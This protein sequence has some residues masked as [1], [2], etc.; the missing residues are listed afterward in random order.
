MF[1]NF[2]ELD[3]IFMDNSFESFPNYNLEPNPYIP[4]KNHIL[5]IDEPDC[6]SLINFGKNNFESTILIAQ[7]NNNINTNINTNTN[8]LN[9][10]TAVIKKRPGRKL[11]NEQT[12]KIHTKN[13]EDN[14]IKKIKTHCMIYANNQ[15]NN[16]HRFTCKKFFKLTPKINENLKKDYNIRLMN[17]TIREIYEENVPCKNYGPSAKKIYYDLIQEIYDKNEKKETIEILNTKFIDFLNR[18]DTKEYI[19]N[20]IKKKQ[21]K[22]NNKIN[23]IIS[24]MNKVKELLEHFEEWFTKKHDRKKNSKKNENNGKIKNN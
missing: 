22:S 4:P 23:D 13:D 1:G 18:L 2:I 24:Y 11:E 19:C 8:N 21:Q 16:R 15:L 17:M 7:D 10:S 6:V 14:I 9:K 3:Q 20:E 12:P 5:S